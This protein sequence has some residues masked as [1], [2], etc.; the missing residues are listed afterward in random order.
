MGDQ[1][2]GGISP[3]QQMVASGAEAVVTSLFMT[4]LDVVKVRLQSQRPLVAG[5]LTPSSRF[6][7]LSA[8]WKCLLYCNGVLEPLYLCP[9]GTRCTTW[10]QDPTRFTGTRPSSHLGDDCASYRRLLHCFPLWPSLPL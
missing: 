3:L 1:D 7:S 8:K 2:P 6:W 4:P 10:F 5:E 9:N